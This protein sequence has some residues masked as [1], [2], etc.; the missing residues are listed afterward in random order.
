[1]LCA[2]PDIIVDRGDARLWCAG[3]IARDYEA[4][5]GKVVWFGKPHLPVYNRC[6]EVL[7]KLTDTITPKSRVLAIGDGIQ[8][9]VPGGIAAGLDVLFVTGGLSST[10]FGSDVEHPEQ[11]PLDAFLSKT[12]L[13][14]K[15][16]IGRLR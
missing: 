7:A 10:E 8:T 13:T 5:G 16:A 12:G 4:A 6:H 15:F 2:N 11:G 3:A 14:P 1:M 9:D